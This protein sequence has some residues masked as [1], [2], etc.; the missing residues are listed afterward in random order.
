MRPFVRPR[1]G[2]ES[3]ATTEQS[4]VARLPLH[5]TD[6]EIVSALRTGSA[7]G[8]AALYDR[9]HRHVRRVLLRVLG[10]PAELLDLEQDAFV[11]AIDTIRRLEDP[12]RLRAWLTSIAV[13]TARREIRRRAPRRFFRLDADDELPELEAPVASPEI[14]EA[15]R[16]TYRIFGKMPTD[17]RIAF[18]LRFVDGMELTEV[19]EACGVSLATVKRRVQRA[20]ERFESMASQYD[21]LSSWRREGRS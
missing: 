2:A 17:E 20:R 19:A 12:E 13:F 10:Q 16:T 1:E 8:G 21:E 7:S 9:Y 4:A 11:T 18:A 6:R 3:R 15:L 5:D 14:D